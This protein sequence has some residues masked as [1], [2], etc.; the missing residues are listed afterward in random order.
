MRAITLIVWVPLG[1]ALTA[2]AAGQKANPSPVSS[3]ARIAWLKRHVA[4]LRSIDP[5]DENSDLEESL[6]GGPIYK[7]ILRRRSLGR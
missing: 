6:S 5:A 4:P 1:G 7:R 2:G 3:E